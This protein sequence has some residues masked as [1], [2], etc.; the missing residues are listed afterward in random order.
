MENKNILTFVLVLVAIFALAFA[1][2][3]AFT[4]RATS[5]SLPSSKAAVALGDLIDLGAL[6]STDNAPTDDTGYVTVM[7]TYIKT[8][9]Q[10]DLSADVAIQCGLVTDTTAKSKGG[11]KDVSSAE[12]K[13]SI[14]VKAT[15]TDSGEVRYFEPSE[16]GTAPDG[17][18]RGVTYCSR[19][20]QLEASFAGLSC[21]A[22]LFTGIV[23]CEDPEE[24]RLLLE[25]LNANSFNYVLADT[26]TGVW[27]IEVQARA[28]SSVALGGSGLG[29]A[30][31]E[32]F[33]GLG[34]TRIE[35]LRLVKGVQTD[36]IQALPL[37]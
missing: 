5:S 26:S 28:E 4:G 14:R 8:P 11:G 20:Q 22:D 32:A 31:G 3:Q 16:S 17:G 7:Q 37:E 9:N 33:V 18:P 13:V 6:A 1:A 10:K 25:T 21:T 2:S 35:T 23:T 29:S 24:L 15:N 27:K 19:F 36:P 12:G 34:S 30:K